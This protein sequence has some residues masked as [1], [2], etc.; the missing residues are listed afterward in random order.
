[1]LHWLLHYSFHYE[2][3]VMGQIG[4]IML[5]WK[6]G[7]FQQPPPASSGCCCCLLPASSLLIVFSF[8][9]IPVGWFNNA[10]AS[11]SCIL[12]LF[13]ACQSFH[14]SI[15]YKYPTSSLCYIGQSITQVGIMFSLFLFP[16]S[17]SL[18]LS[19]SSLMGA[20]HSTH[21]LF[22]FCPTH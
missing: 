6:E 8:V 16:L 12:N 1:M 13:F 5:H 3:A 14:S 17:L 21:F 20:G 10:S 7:K 15:L 2:A 9:S 19:L 18:S 22:F 4:G 11:C